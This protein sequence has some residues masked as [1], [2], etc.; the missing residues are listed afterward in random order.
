MA[1]KLLQEQMES[2]GVKFVFESSIQ[3]FRADGTVEYTVKGEKMETKF[4]K[5]MFAIG[6]TPNVEN[7]GLKEAGI[8]YTAKGVIVNDRLTTSNNH[9]FAVGDC[10]PGPQF[11]HNS[12]VQARTV[13]SNALFYGSKAKSDIILPYCTFTTPEI[14]TVGLNEYSLKEQGILYDAYSKGFDHLDRAICDDNKGHYT[15]YCKKGT[16]QILGATLV[17]GP[18]GDLIVQITS[19]MFNKIGLSKMGACVHPYPSYAEAFKG[20]ADNFNRTKLKPI[21]KS[22]IRGLIYWQK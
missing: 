19:S 7:M 8:E 3:E 4:D 1:A 6:R 18:A 17:G 13:I 5:V 10:I 15:I 2:D 16:D 14:A 11:T 12:D 21:V 9:V 20:M 22:V